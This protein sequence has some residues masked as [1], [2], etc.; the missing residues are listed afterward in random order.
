MNHQSAFSGVPVLS[1]QRSLWSAHHFSENYFMLI[2]IWWI[3]ISWWCN[4][5]YEASLNF[6]WKDFVSA[7]KL[8]TCFLVMLS[9]AAADSGITLYPEP[10]KWEPKWKQRWKPQWKQ[11]WKSIRDIET[12]FWDGIML[13]LR[14]LF[15]WPLS[16]CKINQLEFRKYKSVRASTIFSAIMAILYRG[17]EK[18][19]RKLAKRRVLVVQCLQLYT[20]LLVML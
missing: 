15:R 5:C 2:E 3:L 6:R 9:H 7:G 12:L 11:R 18:R 14:Y 8:I 20:K 10:T 13:P 1:V 16:L 19:T 17:E 4:L